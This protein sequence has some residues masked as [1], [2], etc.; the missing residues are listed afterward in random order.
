[1]DSVYLF[2][3]YGT[4][5][6]YD[7]W[8]HLR[9]LLNWVCENWQRRRRGDLGGA[10]RTAALRLLQVDVLGGAR[11]RAAAGRQALVPRRPRALAPDAGPRSTRRSWR[12]AGIAAPRRLRPGLR[13]ATPWTPRNLLMPLVFFVSPTRSA[14]AGHRSRRSQPPKGAGVGQPGAT[15]TTCDRAP[16]A[17]RARRAPSTSARSGWWRR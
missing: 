6:S 7:L 13:A 12:R 5:I 15:A 16:T 3:K 17:C 4:P 8:A 14:H 10:R 9:R 2:N 1:M 11:P